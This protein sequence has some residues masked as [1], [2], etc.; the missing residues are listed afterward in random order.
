[1][2]LIRR[3]S[4]A[5]TT[6][7]LAALVATGAVAPAGADETSTDPITYQVTIPDEAT[8]ITTR[9]VD[10]NGD[11]WGWSSVR[12]VDGVAEFVASWP[13]SGPVGSPVIEI[14]VDGSD[15]V[16]GYVAGDTLVPTRAQAIAVR[17]PADLGR[18]DLRPAATITGHLVGESEDFSRLSV[19]AGDVGADG[20]RSAPVDLDGS[21]TIRGLD[22]DLSYPLQLMAYTGAAYVGGWVTSEGTTSDLDTDAAPVRAGATVDVALDQVAKIEG[23]LRYAERPLVSGD[24][25]WTVVASATHGERRRVA[26]NASDGSYSIDGLRAGASYTVCV[27][28]GMGNDAGCLG[29]TGAHVVPAAAAVS[30]TAPATGADAVVWQSLYRTGTKPTIDRAPAVGDL[31]TLAAPTWS[32][33]DVTVSYSW[34]SGED[35]AH[36]TVTT[37]AAGS[38]YRVSPDDLGKYVWVQVTATAPNR[39]DGTYGSE[40]WAPV[41]LGAA[42]TMTARISGVARVGSRLAAV[43]TGAQPG[44]TISYTWTSEGRTLGHGPSLTLAAAQ[45]NSMVELVVRGNMPGHEIGVATDTVAVAPG[46]APRALVAPRFSG[47]VRVGSTLKIDPGTWN[48]PGVRFTYTWTSGSITAADNHTSSYKLS[49]S[50]TSKRIRAHVVVSRPGYA[51]AAFDLATGLVPRVRPTVTATLA[52]RSVRSSSRAKVVVKV[53]GQVGPRGTVKVRYGSRSVVVKMTPKS[54]NRVT[55]VLPKL[56]RGT[57]KVSATFTPTG[58]SAS[59]LTPASSSSRTLR[60]R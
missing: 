25:R 36:G 30:V 49:L 24:T 38:T 20:S 8:H 19:Q 47:A 33:E 51:S 57:Y 12:T 29:E 52:D 3:I 2:P 1:M 35:L 13:R 59:C 17:A 48:V 55:V 43:Q 28:A 56:K 18:F 14:E 10:S 46:V 7:A 32:D 31:L 50:D 5:T 42:P 4:R 58:S 53:T 15:Y 11:S 37:N 54:N 45:A 26:Y 21:F 16:G 6:L 60:V 44:T 9:V 23:T 27:S 41:S 34:H 22:P 40:T 39:L